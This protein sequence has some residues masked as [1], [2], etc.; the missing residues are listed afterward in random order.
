MRFCEA[1][2]RNEVA[3]IKHGKKPN[4]EQR[5]LMQEWRLKPEDWLVERDTPE[6]MILVH[7]H[8]DKTTRTIHKEK[9]NGL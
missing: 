2:T 7:R 1:S 4:R 8:S 9:D 5:K 3:I 6:K